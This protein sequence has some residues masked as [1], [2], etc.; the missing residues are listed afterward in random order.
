MTVQEEMVEGFCDALKDSGE[1]Y[2]M[3]PKQRQDAWA[4]VEPDLTRIAWMFNLLKEAAP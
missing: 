1:W 4:E 3:T 2:E